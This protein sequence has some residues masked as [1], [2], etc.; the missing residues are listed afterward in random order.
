MGQVLDTIMARADEIRANAEANEAGGKLTD[1]AA[2]VL[3]ESG[4][5]RMLAPK[6]YGGTESHPREFAETVMATAALDGA[7]GWLTGIVGVHPWELAL[8]DPKVQEEV[9]G[10]DNDTWTASPYAP[11]GIATPTDGGYIL[12]GR[13]SFSSGTDHCQWL[14]IGAMVGNP[15]GTPIMP[16]KVIHV[17][18]PRPDYEIV[19]G[20]W[21]VVGLK[22]T[23][24]KDVTVKGAYIPEYRTIDA[25]KVGDGTLVKE[26]GRTETLY[27]YPYWAIFPLGITSA[28]IGIAE[29]AMACHVAAQKN[30]VAVT[31]TKIK[32]DP[33]VLYA[34]SDAAA[35]IAASRAALL[36]T[37]DRFFDA[38]DAG[39]EVSFEDRARG[40]RTQVAAARRAVR[41]VD[42]IF[43]RSG[44]GALH[45]HTPLQRFWRDAHAGLVHAVHVP[46]SIYHATALLELGGDPQGMMRN[47]I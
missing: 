19:D 41:A 33:Y 4:V 24:S 35:D 30:R 18:V 39:K 8:A 38:V 3:R 43:D 37:T 15:D 40:R 28:V 42:D 20:S 36:E 7:T 21:E 5:M 31:G 25:A 17:L 13:W 32:E 11:M 46:G 6:Q 9:W 27:K 26:Q 44:G 22:G 16:P 47:T 12:N 1:A 2:K 34:I 29:G 23:G 45:L 14:F 10:E